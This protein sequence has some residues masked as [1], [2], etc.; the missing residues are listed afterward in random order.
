MPTKT[1]YLSALANTDS[2][3]G[4][5]R[6][7]DANVNGMA[8]VVLH[9]GSECQLVSEKDTGAAALTA[10]G[11]NGRFNFT[12]GVSNPIVLRFN[13]AKTWIRSHGASSTTVYASITW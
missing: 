5:F 2:T 9:A 11:D 1:I 13:P 6:Q 3:N 8:E 7:F 10:A 4:G 12:G